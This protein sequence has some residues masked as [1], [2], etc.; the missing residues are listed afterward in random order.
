M[1][2]LICIVYLWACW[3][4][5]GHF[6]HEKSP[7]NGGLEDWMAVVLFGPKPFSG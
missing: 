2:V 5:A 1:R 7:P 3:D 4:P 6:G